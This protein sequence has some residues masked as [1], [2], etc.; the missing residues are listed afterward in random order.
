MAFAT[1]S[2]KDAVR[3]EWDLQILQRWANRVGR[4]LSYFGLPGPGMLDVLCWRG[5]LDGRW[6]AIEERPRSGEKRDMADRAVALL[7]TNALAHNLAA[8]LQILRG[9]IGEIILR[10][11]DDYQRRPFL[12]DDAAAHE[13]RFAY[14]LV[15]LDFDG[16]L[17]FKSKSGARRVEAL[18]A[19]FHRQRGRSFVLLLTINVRD[20]LG[21]EIDHYLRSLGADAD[22][23]LIAWYL[24]RGKGEYEFKLKAA[25]PVFLLTAAE[26]HGFDVICH[27][28]VVYT[29]HASARMVHFAL[30]LSWNGQVF[31]AVSRQRARDLL[32]LPFVEAADG[33][34]RLI[35]KDL[36]FCSPSEALESL[37]FL[38]QETAKALSAAG[39]AV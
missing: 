1:S 24:A 25:V 10:A 28:P 22:P 2:N 33:E 15:N 6:T 9:D 36:P 31:P 29:G 21:A 34:L 3:A 16:G 14:D 38:S 13:A 20:T 17:G 18:K 39:V 32:R 19:L 30:E 8:E 26:V 4:S 5:V 37:S 23:E 11:E 12:S 7:E 27:P 35:T